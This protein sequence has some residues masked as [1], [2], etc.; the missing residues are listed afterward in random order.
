M[1][2]RTFLTKS[3]LVSAAAL[4]SPA[5]ASPL[6]EKEAVPVSPTSAPDT[7]PPGPADAFLPKQPLSIEALL[8]AAERI[9][10]MPLAERQRPGMVPRRGIC[11]LSPGR[12]SWDTLLSGN[13]SM[14][15]ELAGHPYTEQLLFHHELLQVPWR[16]PF[17]APKVAS[18]LPRV[19]QLLL[20]GKYREGVNLAYEAMSSA[21]L[22]MNTHPHPTIPAFAMA[23]DTPPAGPVTGYLRTLDFESGEAVVHWR[24]SRGEF[25][26]RTVV[27]RP[28]DVAVQ[29]LQAPAGGTFSPL[30]SIRTPP[31]VPTAFGPITFEQHSTEGRLVL[32]CRFDPAVSNSGYAA[33]TRVVRTGGTAQF[34]SN[35][36]AIHGA[37][38]VLLLTRIFWFDD[39]QQAKLDALIAELDALTGDYAAILNRNRAVQS[40]VIG[41]VAVD[42]G[43]ATSHGLSVE[44]LLDQQRTSLGYSPAL[45]EK[46][47]DM[48]RYWLMLSSGHYPAQ[49]IAG[50]VN[51]N[52]N[53]QIAHGVMTNLPEAMSSYFD[54]IES[55]LPDCRANARNIFGARGAVFPILPNKGMGVSFA[56]AS[57]P[58]Q[59]IWPHPY[60]ISAGGWLYSPFWDHYLVTGD[61]EFLRKRVVP[62][63]KELALFYE[64]FLTLTDERG[65]F[66]FVPSFSPENWPLDAEPVPPSAYPLPDIAW[67]MTPPTPLV[68]NSTMDIMVCR[69]VFTDLLEAAAIL[70]TESG[71]VERWKAMLSKMTPYLLT[72]DG[73]LKE[74]CWP[75]LEENY[76]QR[77]VSHLYGAWPA[78]EI[79]PSRNPALAHAALLADRKRG[80]SNSSAH[81]LCHRALAA[82][83]LK[84]PYLVNFE[85]KQLLE[86]GYFGSTLRS[87][88]NPFRSPFPDAQGGVPTILLE[89]I[90]YSRP[91]VL[92]LLPALPVTLRKGSIQGVLARTFARIDHLSWNLEERTADL[93]LTSLRDQNL[94]LVVWHGISSITGPRNTVTNPRQSGALKCT[95]RLFAN[96]PISFKIKL[97]ASTAREWTREAPTSRA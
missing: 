66:I 46:V 5:F 9:H 29:L 56:Y 61:L 25:I 53:L 59:G 40:S 95:L 86:Q 91:G 47:F 13:G 69:E 88:H 51:I 78:D 8:P 26:R 39:F 36:L 75:S 96:Q 24:D 64:D 63:L 6:S 71:N 54:W 20:E 68:I 60:W 73:T 80:P 94:T 58:N 28:D 37:T 17:E 22:P 19:R 92:E 1:Q 7:L 57:T 27:S 41:R 11:S 49:P 2:R 90:T 30:L 16:R 79:D 82:T 12:P 31:G 97:A 15:T 74:W 18:V 4:T 34:V 23:I 21:G 67:Q 83:R 14:Y 81:G 44:E 45:L 55:L 42:L 76:D 52:V 62:G 3:A 65:N 85:L 72:K 33:V 84:D 87:S 38:Q 89:A 43:G 70:G 50:E 48:G 10:P 77:H 93:T 32:T 35:Q